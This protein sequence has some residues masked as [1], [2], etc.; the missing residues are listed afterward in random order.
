MD[1]PSD[2]A[3]IENNSLGAGSDLF[4]EYH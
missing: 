2:G 4:E 3:T 1:I